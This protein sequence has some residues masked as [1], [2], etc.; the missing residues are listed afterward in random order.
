M[1]KRRVYHV[2]PSSDGDWKVKEN[3]SERAVKI[4][5]RKTDALNLA[6]ELAKNAGLGQVIIHKSD[7]SIQTEYTYGQDSEKT[8]G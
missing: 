6:K 2:L 5:E 4:L 1:S 8:K 3:G 7:G